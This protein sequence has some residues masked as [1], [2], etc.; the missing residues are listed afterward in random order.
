MCETNENKQLLNHENPAFKQVWKDFDDVLKRTVGNMML[1]KAETASLTLKLDLSLLTEDIGPLD[2]VN[3][4]IKPSFK[5]Q[6]NSVMQVKDKKS[7]HFNDDC[8]VVWDSELCEYVTR[9]INDPQMSFF[10]DDEDDYVDA[11]GRNIEPLAL[12]SHEEDYTSDIE[13]FE[14]D[15]P[16][17]DEEF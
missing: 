3:E 15:E 8:E 12:E 10:H 16:E 2:E 6:I 9:P 4:I 5:H 17:F 13:E 7:G 11:E 14:I 1:K